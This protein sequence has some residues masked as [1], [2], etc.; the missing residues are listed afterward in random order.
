[1]FTI[2]SRTFSDLHG[3]LGFATPIGVVAVGTQRPAGLIVSPADPEGAAAGHAT[4]TVL[5]GAGRELRV[6][7]WTTRA[8]SGSLTWR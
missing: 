2:D 7:Y 3:A 5:L 6:T 8:D 4:P 1:M